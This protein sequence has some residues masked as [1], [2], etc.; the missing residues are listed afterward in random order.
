MSNSL[1]LDLGLNCLTTLGGKEFKNNFI[2][3]C[4]FGAYRY[5]CCFLNL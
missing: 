4:F 3:R 1:D 5:A 2:R